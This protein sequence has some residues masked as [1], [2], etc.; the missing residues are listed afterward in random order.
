MKTLVREITDLNFSLSAVNRAMITAVGNVLTSGWTNPELT[1]SGQVDN[2]V[3][4]DFV[5]ES[6]GGTVSQLITEI[7]A[8]KSLPLAGQKIVVRSETN[9]RSIQLPNPGDQG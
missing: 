4:F 6:P 5:A 9:E 2:G 1:D 8:S 3:R 7:T